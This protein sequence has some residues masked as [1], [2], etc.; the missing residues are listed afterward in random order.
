[1]TA[2]LRLTVRDLELLPDP[3]D[4]TRYELIDGV[5]HVSK[6]P[7]YEHQ[8]LCA[9]LA[10]ELVQWNRQ[11]GLGRVTIA[12]GVIFAPDEAVAPDLVW[13]GRAREAQVVGKDGKLHAPPDLVIE[14]LSPGRRNQ[15]RDRELKLDL[16]SR[17][18]VREYWIVAPR[19]R[20]LAVYR[21]RQGQ[22]T[23]VATLRPGD[24]LESPVLPG[25]SLSLTELFAD[26]SI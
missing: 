18:Q 25:F 19:Q 16:Y 3:L 2:A 13:V 24:T 14:V 12:P 7:S 17:Y 22:L 9:E 26:I 6:Q 21:H 11:S 4:D 5:L 1:M 8:W 15:Q 10:F 23:L 20:T